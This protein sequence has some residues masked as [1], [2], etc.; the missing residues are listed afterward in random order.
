MTQEDCIYP[1]CQIRTQF[2]KACEHS[3]EYEA[4]MKRPKPHEQGCLTSQIE[5]GTCQFPRCDC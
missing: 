2:S 4:R 1:D 5:G 3:C